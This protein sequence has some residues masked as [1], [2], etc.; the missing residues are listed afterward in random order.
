MLTLFAQHDVLDCKSSATDPGLVSTLASTNDVGLMMEFV[1]LM[2]V[3]ASDS[4]G[5]A[6]LLQSQSS[7]ISELHKILISAPSAMLHVKEGV[8]AAPYK[9]AVRSYQPQVVHPK[10]TKL[11][12]HPVTSEVVYSI[13]T[14]RL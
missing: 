8:P 4:T 14:M 12:F 6:Y 5:R 10:H 7:V 11:G 9:S 2:S 1:R 3:L 13:R